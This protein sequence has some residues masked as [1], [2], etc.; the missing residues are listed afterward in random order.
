VWR[1][2][3]SFQAALKEFSVALSLY[4][5]EKVSHGRFVADHRSS[6]TPDDVVMQSKAARQQRRG[7]FTPM[8]AAFN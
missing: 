8:K 4:D 6:C 5:K 2:V 7:D 3:S 1:Q